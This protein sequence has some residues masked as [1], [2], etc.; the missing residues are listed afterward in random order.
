MAKNLLI[1][2]FSPHFHFNE[3]HSIIINADKTII[4]KAIMNLKVEEISPLM[5]ILIAL[6]KWPARIAG[7][8]YSKVSGGVLIDDMLNNNFVM[9]EECENEIVLG[10]IGKFWKLINPE[11]IK[12]SNKDEFL[13]FDLPD[14]GIVTTNMFIDNCSEKNNQKLSTETRIYIRDNNARNKFR[15]YWSLIYPG[16]SLI[17]YVWIKAIKKKA[18]D[19]QYSNNKFG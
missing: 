2:N 7:K 10:L 13:N 3:Y 16:S 1:D 5:N 4:M 9:L 6:R 18:E 19:L 11:V 17:R 12:I 15:I 14:F 8:K